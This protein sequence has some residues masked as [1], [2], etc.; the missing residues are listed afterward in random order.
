MFNFI[1]EYGRYSRRIGPPQISWPI[2]YSL[3]QVLSSWFIPLGTSYLSKF[4]R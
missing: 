1:L 4:P 3:S 2:N